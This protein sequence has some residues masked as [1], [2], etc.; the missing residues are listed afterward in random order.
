MTA[1]LYCTG[2]DYYGLI[3][4]SWEMEFYQYKATM[5]K[6]AWRDS[7]KAFLV[8]VDFWPV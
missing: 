6:G 7:I 5:W 1:N 8:P 3:K 4:V 2:Y